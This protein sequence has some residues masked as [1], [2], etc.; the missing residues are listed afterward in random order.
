MRLDGAFWSRPAEE[1]LRSLA[2]G[3]E[4][5]SSAA[6]ASRLATAGP[7]RLQAARRTTNFQLLVRQFA[8]PLV[9]MLAAAAVLSLAVR[10]AGDAIIILLILFATGLLGFWQERAAADAVRKLLARVAVRTRVVRDGREREAPLEEI[11]PGDVVI[12]AAGALVPADALLLESKDLFVDE[13]TLTGETYPAEKQPGAVPADAPLS[14]RTPALFLGT[15]VVSGTARAV[16]VRTGRNTEFGQVS[17]RLA[18]RPPE[19]DFERGIHR[20]G[21]LLL[22]VTVALVLIIFGANVFLDRPAIEAFMFSLAL[23]V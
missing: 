6:A 7:N 17:S 12:L 13:A 8:S 21:Y 11:V 5:L 23:A 14:R 15:H 19:S 3:S 18:L 1:V 16:V 20:F 2:T 22:R 9:L 10:E 4:G